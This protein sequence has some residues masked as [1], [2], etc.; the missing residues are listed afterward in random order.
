MYDYLKS[1]FGTDEKGNEVSLTF[2]QFV[3]R[4]NAAEGVELANIAGG[5]YVSEDKYNADT[6][7]LRNRLGAQERD[8]AERTFLSGYRFTSKAAENG[9]LAE[10]RAKN[11]KVKNGSIPEGEEFMKSLMENDD[12]KAAFVTEKDETAQEAKELRPVFA[13]AASGG[14]AGDDGAG[15]RFGFTHLR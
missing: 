7:E 6:G 12:Y 9:V 8:F 3:E 5:G 1:V 15:F 4:L 10:L 14:D 2:S 13:S 11:F